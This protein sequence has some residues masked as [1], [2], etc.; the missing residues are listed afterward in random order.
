M[1]LVGIRKDVTMFFLL[2]GFAVFLIGPKQLRGNYHPT[3]RYE[4]EYHYFRD[5]NFSK[6]YRSAK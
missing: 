2:G 1:R 4:W 5:A 6:Y 3:D